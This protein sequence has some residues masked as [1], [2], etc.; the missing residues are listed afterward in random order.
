MYFGNQPGFETDSL[1]LT[2]T[3]KDGDGNLGLRPDE[4]GIPFHPFN[5]FID[6]NGELF[7]AFTLEEITPEMKITRKRSKSRVPDLEDFVEPH[8]CDHYLYDTLYV[9]EEETSLFDDTYKSFLAGTDQNGLKY[10]G[11]A[12]TFYVAKNLNYYNIEVSIWTYCCTQGA[13]CPCSNPEN[14]ETI[15]VKT[16]DGENDFDVYKKFEF[17]RGSWPVCGETF[18]GRFPFI[19]RN[20]DTPMEGTIS[21]SMKS[22]GFVDDIGL[23]TKFVLKVRIRDRAL[24]ASNEDISSPTTLAE[25]IR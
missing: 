4:E 19:A 16:G 8:D 12:D 21:Y 1:Q 9:S 3:F 18:D 17:P 13:N 15:N 24:N 14:R 7:D 20:K 25:I 23:D 22:I 2:I 10:Y 11:V 5:Y 6:A